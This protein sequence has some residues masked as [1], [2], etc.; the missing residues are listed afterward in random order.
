MKTTFKTLV[1]ALALLAAVSCGNNKKAA[2]KAAVE[3]KDV[4][5]SVTVQTVHIQ[6]VPQIG[7]YTSTVQAN[8]VNN[9]APQSPL[10]IKK[11]LVEVGDF[12]T[13]GQKVAEMDVVNLN[14]TRLQLINDSTELSRLKELYATGGISQ[15]DYE[16]AE[17]GYKVRKS[18]YENLLENTIL[19]API[20]GVITAR[21]YDAGDMFMSAQPLYTVQQITPVKLLV[22]ISEKDYTK[23]KK[24]DEVTLTTEAFKDQVFKGRIQRIHPTIDAAT[25]TF[26][27]EVVVSNADRKLRPGMYATVNVNYGVN[28]SV[29][30]PDVALV[31]QQG[32]GD[33]FAYV[34]QP[35]GTVKF[36]KVVM[37]VQTGK[38]VEILSGLEDGDQ[39]VTEGH[40][41]I[42]DGVKVQVANK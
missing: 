25:H 41:R 36:K 10:R 13:K 26:N 39:V 15:S 40:L 42:K 3:V 37:G 2:E 20:S 30:V 31:K 24:G 12:V 17:L 11:I 22:G 27:V 29:V 38:D 6:D 19:R 23:V 9:I 5:P 16:A 35:D 18:S 33:R 4:I 1:S 7:T 28:K 34:L 32:S 14:T 21:N 8:I